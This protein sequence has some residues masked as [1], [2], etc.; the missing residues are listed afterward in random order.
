[1]SRPCQKALFSCSDN[2]AKDTEDA[3][4]T[5]QKSNTTKPGVYYEKEKERERGYKLLST[6]NKKQRHLSRSQPSRANLQALWP[7]KRRNILRHLT[8]QACTWA[9]RSQRIQKNKCRVMTLVGCRGTSKDPS[10]VGGKIV[11]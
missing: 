5:Q 10:I 11:L 7:P 4:Q 1:M 8:F 6:A 3:D 9:I 2:W